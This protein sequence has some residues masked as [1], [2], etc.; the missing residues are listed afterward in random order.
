M[1]EIYPEPSKS[2][3]FPMPATLP[4]AESDGVNFTNYVPD[5][6]IKAD[7]FIAIINYPQHSQTKKGAVQSFQ[8]RG[9]LLRH[10]QHLKPLLQKGNGGYI[11]GVHPACALSL[12]F[13]MYKK[14]AG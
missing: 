5:P 8:R 1:P 12:R 3:S 7:H 4:T 6:G 2:A 11:K 14:Q 9:P 10:A 13:N